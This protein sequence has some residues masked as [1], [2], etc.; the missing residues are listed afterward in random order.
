MMLQMMLHPMLHPML[1]L[2]LHLMLQLMLQMMLLLRPLHVLV[3]VSLAVIAVMKF[4]AE[5]CGTKAKRHGCKGVNEIL[6]PHRVYPCIDS[7]CPAQ[8]AAES[9]VVLLDA[10]LARLHFCLELLIV[11]GS[12]CMPPFREGGE[13]LL[14]SG[15][16]SGGEDLQLPLPVDFLACRLVDWLLQIL[17]S[18][19]KAYFPLWN[20]MR[21]DPF[22]CLLRQLQQLKQQG[23][24]KL[25]HLQLDL[26]GIDWKPHVLSL[27]QHILQQQGRKLQS[28][29]LRCRLPSAAMAT[30]LLA[31]PSSVRCLNIS[32]NTLEADAV[33]ALLS[34]LRE[35]HLRCLR[36]SNA[37]LS[38][39]SQKAIVGSLETAGCRSSLIWFEAYEDIAGCLQALPQTLSVCSTASRDL[40]PSSACHKPAGGCRVRLVGE[41]N[42]VEEDAASRLSSGSGAS[43]PADLRQARGGAPSNCTVLPTPPMCAEEP[44]VQARLSRRCELWRKRV[45]RRLRSPC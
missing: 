40:S 14:L 12:S 31:I 36:A 33:E 28:V 18:R 38:V 19:H 1:H 30:L 13:L 11:F 23:F 15:V 2:V 27:L 9:E 25:R 22:V 43:S 6:R 34:V 39:T 45:R 10:L 7:S 5:D 41:G 42:P 8:K 17:S 16:S 24:P 4:L 32:E 29:C 37:D 35:G 3:R 21:Q 20:D 44:R 26:V